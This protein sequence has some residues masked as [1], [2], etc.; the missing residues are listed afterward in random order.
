MAVGLMK[1]TK[2]FLMLENYRV[3]FASKELA[4]NNIIFNLYDENLIELPNSGYLRFSAPASNG[5]VFLS[6]V[7]NSNNYSLN[8]LKSSVEI[9][10]FGL[11]H[12]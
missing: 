5:K 8:V 2:D 12:P 6:N 4:T 3:L 9:Y 7:Y 10:F 11:L 1:N